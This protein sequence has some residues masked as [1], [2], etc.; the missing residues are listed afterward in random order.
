MRHLLALLLIAAN[1]FA[2]PQLINYQGQLATGIN[3]TPDT[4]VAMTFTIYNASRAARPC[5][6]RPI[7]PWS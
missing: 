2:V 3:S 1:A 5:G 4:T 7:R 6:L